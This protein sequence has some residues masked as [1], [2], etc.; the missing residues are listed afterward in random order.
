MF[1]NLIRKNYDMGLGAAAIVAGGSLLG[2]GTNAYATGRMNRATR[3]FA[4]EQADVT[5]QRNIANWKMQ[6]EYNE[7]M[8]EKQ[9]AYDQSMRD[10]QRMYDLD[11]YNMENEYNTPRNQMQRFQEAGLNPH[12]IAGS[13][14]AMG[15]SVSTSNMDTTQQGSSQISGAEKAEWNPRAPQFDF[16]SGLIAM[17]D[18]KTKSAQQDLLAEQAKLTQKEQDLV[19]AKSITELA[20]GN[21]KG[22]E[23]KM[24][25]ELYGTSI[26][27][28]QEQLRKLQADTR[29]TINQD[30]RSERALN[31][32]A[33]EAR[34]RIDLL[35][36]QVK[37]EAQRQ[38]LNNAEIMIKKLEA[39]YGS[40][41]FG[42]PGL[43]GRIIE[44]LE[45]KFK[46]V[47]KNPDGTYQIWW[48]KN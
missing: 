37:T 12:M 36:S 31:I 3:Q 8:W 42:I 20:G 28:R 23:F 45:D 18:M 43:F 16:H 22:L 39:T 15:G 47:N 13:S 25:S 27:A 14:N 38:E 30:T 24:E 26:Q 32:T 41:L 35:K 21:M 6:N 5:N 46:T 1:D 7:R 4:Q 44:G 17:M 33:D 9:N 10:N 29:F 2:Q 34:A 48:D 40:G 19:T 11:M